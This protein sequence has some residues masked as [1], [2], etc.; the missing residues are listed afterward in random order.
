MKKLI[1]QRLASTAFTSSI[2]N[3]LGWFWETSRAFRSWQQPVWCH[4]SFAVPSCW[5]LDD[6]AVATLCRW[7]WSDS[8]FIIAHPWH[9]CT[10]KAAPLCSTSR[11]NFIKWMKF[12]GEGGE[13]GSDPSPATCRR[14]DWDNSWANLTMGQERLLYSWRAVILYPSRS[15]FNWPPSNSKACPGVGL[16]SNYNHRKEASSRLCTS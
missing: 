1:N 9:V 5:M 10:G 14:W 12:Q 7:R 11:N 16:P 3:E 15:L 4:W 6:Q 2:C 8:V 13:K